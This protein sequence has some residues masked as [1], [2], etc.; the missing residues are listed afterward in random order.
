MAVLATA[1][2]TPLLSPQDAAAAST[3]TVSVNATQSLATFAATGLGM[4]VAVYDGQM[5]SAATPGLLKAAGIG[6][7]RYPGGSYGDIYHWKTN[8]TE[9]G[10]VADNTGF[11][12]FMGTVT[13]SGAQPVII[14]NYGTGTPQEA[15]DWVRYANVTKGYAAKYWEIGNEV[16]G[17]GLYGSGWEQDNHSSHTATTYAN[18]LVQYISAMKAVDP[19]IKVGAVLTTPGNWPDGIVGTGDTQDWNHTV[20]SI[21]G[22]KIDFVIVHHYPNPASS[23]ELLTRPQ[24]DVPAISATLKSLIRQYAGANAA[25]VGIAVTETNSSYAYDT[26]PAGLFAADNYLT[27]VENGAFNVDWWDLRNGTDCSKITTIAGASEFGDGGVLSSG[28]SCEPPA[29]T[30]FPTYYGIQMAS[31]LAKPGDALV[32]TTS[33]QPLLTS[34]AA[35]A[36]NGDVSVLLI[37]K[38]P[39]NATTVNLS[40]AGFSPA[41]GSPT[42]YT[43]PL[44]GHAITTSSSGSAGTQTVPA[45]SMV[46]VRVHPAGSTQT[47][48]PTTPVPTT[49]PSPTASSTPP[50]GPGSCRV[51]YTKSEWTGG[52]TA[53]VV[54]TN[55]GTSA[56]DGWRLAFAFPGDTKVTNAWN[57]TV[58]QNGSSAT[59]TNVAYNASIAAGASVNFGFQ[60]TWS[61]NDASP[62][63]F[64]LNGTTCI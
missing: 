11:D 56:I 45:Y 27:W 25:N 17:N 4:N 64:A 15:A 61:T 8:T 63:S 37:N 54:V 13:T 34:H 18:N 35:R 39:V 20:L 31:T 21:A 52:L 12:A 16:Y 46:V 50:A 41:A 30:P 55:T 40:Y 28:A 9:G 53:T 14:A 57:A 44:N 29:N 59:A 7:V 42:V 24:T 43:Y 58:T 38:D 48:S 60:G 49:V 10:Y 26:A 51:A 62:T 23:A 2:L 5:N 22:S 1:T 33:S 36:G 32:S 47:P 3:A 19:T 6:A